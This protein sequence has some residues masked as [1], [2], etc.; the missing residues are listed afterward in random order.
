MSILIT[1]FYLLF[2]LTHSVRPKVCG[3]PV[4]TSRIVGGTDAVEGEWPWQI[5]LTF[6]DSHICGGSLIA[7]QWVLT[8]AHCFVVSSNP[9]RYKVYLGMYK[10]SVYNPHGGWVS[11]ESIIVNPLYTVNSIGDIALMKLEYPV[12]YTHYILP[13]CLPAASVTFPC[14]MEC[15]VTGWG[16]VTYEVSLPNP[17]TLQK[18]MTPLIDSVTCDEMYHV[19]SSVSTS[20]IIIQEEKI[21]AGYKEGQRDSCQGDSGGPLVCKVQGAWFQAGIVSGGE[22]CAISNRPGVY[23]LVTA[24]ESWISSYVPG[25]KFIKLQNI[26]Q[27]STK[28]VRGISTSSSNGSIK[29]PRQEWKMLL[30][31]AFILSQI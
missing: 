10:L 5:S 9:L 22:G 23:T 25:V 20:S 19:G 1:C 24:Y 2:V 16:K 26:P 12:T 21:C 3:T 17:E 6:N 13:V 28:C 18:V 4:A 31:A 30:L 27:P 7:P 29:I 8:A 11:V 14:G 15:W